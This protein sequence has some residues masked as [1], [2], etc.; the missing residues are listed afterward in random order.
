MVPPE[1][2]ELNAPTTLPADFGEWDSSEQAAAQP[3]GNPGGFDGFPGAVA[4]PKPVAKTVTA[5]VAVLPV[6]PKTLLPL[7]GVRRQSTRRPSRPINSRNIVQQRRPS[8]PNST[9]KRRRLDCLSV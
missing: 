5:R 3:T 1:E 2:I 9:K 4:A 7:R 8:R 6:A